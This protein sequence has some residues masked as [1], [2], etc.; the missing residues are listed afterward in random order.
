MHDAH[1]CKGSLAM[2]RAESTICGSLA[3]IVCL[4][5][6]VKV[7]ASPVVNAPCLA[8]CLCLL[9]G[10]H[11]GWASHG[12]VHEIAIEVARQE[13]ITCLWRLGLIGEGRAKVLVSHHV[14]AP[15]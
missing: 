4:V 12:L 8:V 1:L 6:T 2:G 15:A 10:T 9:V 11:F 3:L 7:G 13:P 14:A 5:T